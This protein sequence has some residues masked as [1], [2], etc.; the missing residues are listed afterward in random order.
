M[1]GQGQAR[2]LLII[3]AFRDMNE[4]SAGDAVALDRQ[5]FVQVSVSFTAARGTL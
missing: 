5:W 3:V 4:K 2:R 1:E